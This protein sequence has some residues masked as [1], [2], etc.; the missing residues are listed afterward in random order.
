MDHCRPTATLLCEPT[1]WRECI[2]MAGRDFVCT[3]NALQLP[4]FLF[5]RP[6]LQLELQ[7]ESSLSIRKS[8]DS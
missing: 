7:V 5:I 2:A 6:L 4:F 1:L 8:T 3:L